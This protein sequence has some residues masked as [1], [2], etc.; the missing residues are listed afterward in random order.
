MR[1]RE[2]GWECFGW[3]LPPHR[4]TGAPRFTISSPYKAL[5]SSFLFYRPPCT[6]HHCV[7]PFLRLGSPLVVGLISCMVHSSRER[8]SA[9]VS[10][11]RVE[12]TGSGG[13]RWGGACGSK[14]IIHGAEM[15]LRRFLGRLISFSFSLSPCECRARIHSLKTSSPGQLAYTGGVAEES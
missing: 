8:R 15:T 14:M 10:G 6:Y 7:A 5:I 2:W 3:Y 12:R 9:V 11:E 1:S 13:R 4:A